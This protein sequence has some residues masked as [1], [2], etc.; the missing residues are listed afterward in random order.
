MKGVLGYV[1]L[2]LFVAAAL[3]WGPAI[4]LGPDAGVGA[5]MCLVPA[6]FALGVLYLL[7]RFARW[8][9][10]HGDPSHGDR[11]EAR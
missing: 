7:V 9:W 10:S 6:A 2:F 5:S 4:F 11:D 8:A 3:L 1:L